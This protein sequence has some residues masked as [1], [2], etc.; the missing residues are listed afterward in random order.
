MLV[1]WPVMNGTLLPT[2][3]LASSLSSVIRFGVDTMLVS[4]RDC[5]ARATAASP[6]VPPNLRTTPM[7]KP[8]PRPANAPVAVVAPWLVR[9]LVPPLPKLVPM[10]PMYLL[11]L[12]PIDLPLEAEVGG[13]VTA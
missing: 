5:S 1:N 13:V 2:T 12:L 11:S 8:G 4:A 7:L 9:M 10:P 6:K 3:I